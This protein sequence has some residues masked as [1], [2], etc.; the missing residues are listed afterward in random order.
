MSRNGRV[1]ANERSVGETG[2]L[3]AI[4]DN[5]VLYRKRK[6]PRC[7]GIQRSSRSPVEFTKKCC[8]SVSDDVGGGV[9]VSQREGPGRHSRL[10]F[11]V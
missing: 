8:G 1:V 3:G 5:A 6:F 4:T 11:T 9:T 7:I 2:P 10:R